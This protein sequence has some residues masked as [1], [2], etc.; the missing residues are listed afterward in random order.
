MVKRVQPAPVRI[1]KGFA[2]MAG[3]WKSLQMSLWGEGL[4]HM[5]ETFETFPVSYA[6]FRVTEKPKSFQR[7]GPHNINVLSLL[8]GS[9]LGDAHA[10]FRGGSTRVCF[11]QE[12]SNASYLYW[13]HG[14][15]AR[16]GYC[17][18]QK[19]KLSYRIGKGGKK[20]FV[21][22]FKTWSFQSLNWLHHTFYPDGVKQVPLPLLEQYLNGLAL[23]V[24][25]MDDGTRSGSGLSVST[26]CFTHED[27]LKIQLFLKEKW[28][29][30]ASLHKCGAK[31][32]WVLYFHAKT[33]PK[34]AS[35]VKPYLVKNMQHKLGKWRSY[36]G[37]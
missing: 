9:L 10:E 25:I 20:R 15:L 13:L 2:F 22:R 19:P 23:A 6:F 8:F 27:L 29:F 5:D 28:A 33:M 34:L 16:H 26:N 4:P 31:N 14:F 35:L 11:Q 36:L 3:V 17:S 30:K 18:D 7:V 21:L 1:I 37:S 24:W 12:N 32:Q